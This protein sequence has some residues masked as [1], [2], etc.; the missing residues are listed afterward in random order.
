MIHSLLESLP[1]LPLQGTLMG[2]SVLTMMALLLL[3]SFASEDLACVSAG[4]LAASEQLPLGLGIL[5]CALGIW[6]GD[7]G[8]YAVGRGVRHGLLQ[9]PWAIQFVSPERLAAGERYL[10]QNGTRFLFASR[11][12]PGSRLPGYLAA[13][14]LRYPLWKFMLILAIGAIVW[15]PLLCL[16]ALSLGMSI[17]PWLHDWRLWLAVP[18]VW[19]VM[20]LAGHL[21]IGL[22]TWRGRRLLLSRWMR[23]THWEFWPSW[24]FYPPVA[25]WFIWLGI[26]HRSLTVFTLC[27]PGIRLGGLVIESK[28]AI[29][30]ALGAHNPHA[31]AI[32]PWTLLAPAEPA[33]RLAA[34]HVF[35]TAHDLAYPIVLKPD[36]GERGQ[37][38]AIVRDEQAARRYLSSC[39]QGVIAQRYIG[40]LEFGVF[41]CR[42]PG[43]KTGSIVSLSQKH[44]FSL[45][46]DGVST[47]EE[48]ILTHPRALAMAPYYLK[49]FAERLAHVP[50]FGVEVKLAEIG[51]H[52]RGAIFTDAR[53]HL[54]EDL[55]R[56]ID[57]LTQPFRGF[58]YGRYDLRV[59]NLED[60]KAGRNIQVL[61]LNGVTAEPVHVY[62]PG[63]PLWRGWQDVCAC[64]SAAFAAGAAVRSTGHQAPRIREVLNE[65]KKHRHHAWFE[66]D[67]LL[68]NPT[69]QPHNPHPTGFPDKT[70]D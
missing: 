61:E 7:L 66:A 45:H 19:L 56:E 22:L 34:L 26:R 5:A 23:L 58:H 50:A 31:S 41:Y 42:Q 2:M 53:Q 21:A 37:G 20:G 46:G 17:L 44:L 32:A 47:L 25:L 3:S 52:C 8:L 36:I 11:F 27:N 57:A 1:G 29:L 65:L 70:H 63:Y 9:W 4:L 35:M 55:C 67:D 54:T 49:K 28:S 69:H 30:T 38:V 33:E 24:A 62:Q 13:G 39:G 15:T 18:F 60:L 51:T 68:K 16:L 59:P 14:A 6:I 64:L 12:L 43:D 10:T 48:L 40:G